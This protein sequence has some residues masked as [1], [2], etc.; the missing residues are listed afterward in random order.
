[1][2][3]AA[4]R[5]LVLLLVYY[6][7]NSNIPHPFSLIFSVEFIIINH[8]GTHNPFVSNMGEGAAG[9]ILDDGQAKAYSKK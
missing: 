2:A 9:V 7:C 1:M 4:T 8:F 5:V 3:R 6:C